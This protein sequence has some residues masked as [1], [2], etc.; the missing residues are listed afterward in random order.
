[1]TE[2]ERNQMGMRKQC[3]HVMMLVA[4]LLGMTACQ[5]P[6]MSPPNANTSQSELQNRTVLSRAV[7]AVIWGIPAVNYDRMYQA[8]EKAGG[9]PNQ[10]VHWSRPSDWKNQLLTPNTDAIYILPFFN[11]KEVGPMVL[12]IPPAGDGTIVGTIM[13]CWQTPLEDVGPAGADAG[14]G[15]RY[16]LTPPGFQGK[17]PAGY[18]TL[19]SLNFQGYALLRSIPK[20]GSDADIATAVSYL[21]RIKL[22]PLSAA[23]SPPGIKV[24]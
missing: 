18:I 14:K 11:T 4:T 6:T 1:M 8:L 17:A 23:S 19:P 10:L 13:D 24:C 22:Y 12:E 9:G 3:T 21:K 7:Q 20:T 16:L 5:K 2:M 15:G